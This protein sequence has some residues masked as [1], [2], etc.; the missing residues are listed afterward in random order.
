M[1][2]HFLHLDPDIDIQRIQMVGQRSQQ[3][4]DYSQLSSATITGL[5]LIRCK[6]KTHLYR[7]RY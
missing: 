1:S 4:I 3:A 7:G 2:D 6:L 5:T